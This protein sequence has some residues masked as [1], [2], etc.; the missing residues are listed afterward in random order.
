MESTAADELMVT[1]IVHGHDDRLRSFELLGEV[2]ER[3][4]SL[5]RSAAHT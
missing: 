1:T 5:R 3:T 2:A 4:P